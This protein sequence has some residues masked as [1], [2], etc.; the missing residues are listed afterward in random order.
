V[1][2]L[3]GA[4]LHK[5]LDAQLFLLPQIAATKQHYLLISIINMVTDVWL[6]E[7]RALN[8]GR[9]LFFAVKSF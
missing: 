5:V 7:T 2:L 1:L 3:S 8:I 9:Y 4:F 6:T